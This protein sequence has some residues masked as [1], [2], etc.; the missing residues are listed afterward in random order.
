MDNEMIER[1]AKVICKSNKFETGEGTCSLICMDQ[2]GNARKDC[3]H[4]KNIHKDSTIVIIKA[5]REPT[6]KMIDAGLEHELGGVNGVTDI[7]TAMI[8]A[9]LND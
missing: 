3:Y 7:Y 6:E 2:L 9:I 1:V 8:D 4:A 5:M